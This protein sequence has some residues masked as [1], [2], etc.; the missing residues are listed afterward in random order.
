MR[1]R[2]QEGGGV[3]SSDEIIPPNLQGNGDEGVAV[4]CVDFANNSGKNETEPWAKQQQREAYIWTGPILWAI[5]WAG[6]HEILARDNLKS[7][8]NARVKHYR[9]IQ[10]R[11]INNG[12][13]VEEL[14]KQ[15]IA[16][17]RYEIPTTFTDLAASFQTLHCTATPRDVSSRDPERLLNMVI[18]CALN[19]KQPKTY[20][21]SI[22]IKK[23]M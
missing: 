7:N 5:V 1:V 19:L 21:I 4:W 14:K 13:R 20:R 16:C 8:T 17:A 22:I 18:G 15:F 2:C 23:N 10:T 6:R 9:M 12:W 3:N 11:S